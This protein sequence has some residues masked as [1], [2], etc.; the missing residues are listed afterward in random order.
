MTGEIIFEYDEQNDIVTAIPKWN[1]ETDEDCK[2]WFKQWEDYISK[3]GRK[4]DCI[5]IL[6][7]FNVKSDVAAEWGKYRVDLVNNYTRFSYRVNSNLVTGIYIKTSGIRY[8]GPS[9]EAN[10]KEAAIHAIMEDRKKA[11]IE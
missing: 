3:F 7:D 9:N 4:V 5:M 8:N 6:D 2:V 1:I 10:S 11:G